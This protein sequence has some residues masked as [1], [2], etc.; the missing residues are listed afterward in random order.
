M[1]AA[2]HFDV[3]PITRARS[4]R[5]QKT[6]LLLILLQTIGEMGERNIGRNLVASVALL[7]TTLH[8]SH[9]HTSV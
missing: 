3:E 6:S 2:T 4:G 8:Q 5:M 7:S 9:T 1:W